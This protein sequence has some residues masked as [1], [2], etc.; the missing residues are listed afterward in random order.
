VASRSNNSVYARLGMRYDK[1]ASRVVRNGEP[2][3]AWLENM[4]SYGRMADP[5]TDKDARVKGGK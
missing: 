3:F 2:G 4:R 5:R 1:V